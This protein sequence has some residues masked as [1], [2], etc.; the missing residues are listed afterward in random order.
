MQRISAITLLFKDLNPPLHHRESRV[1]FA[2]TAMDAGDRR[3]GGLDQARLVGLFGSD[4][5]VI[6]HDEAFINPP[7]ADVRCT[8]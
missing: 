5:A 8:Q 7:R 6:E 4:D 2:T 1:V 3:Q